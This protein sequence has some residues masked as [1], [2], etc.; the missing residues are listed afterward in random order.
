[1]GML[2]L[3]RGANEVVL[4]RL[5]NGQIGRV[6]VTKIMEKNCRV[7][8]DF[9]DNCAIVREEVEF[10]DKAAKGTPDAQ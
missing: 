8:F 6:T 5:P 4:I 9:P 3:T 2:V 10:E 7:G 1:M